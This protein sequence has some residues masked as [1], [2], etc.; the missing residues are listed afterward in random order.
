MI[1]QTPYV[2]GAPVGT[3]LTILFNVLMSEAKTGGFMGAND[4]A[5][6]AEV[7]ELVKGKIGIIIDMVTVP[8]VSEHREL[9]S[10]VCLF[11][12]E[13][14]GTQEHGATLKLSSQVNVTANITKGRLATIIVGEVEKAFV[15]L[16]APRII[17]WISM[18]ILV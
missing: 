16:L 8:T 3:P 10:S 14:D 1:E 12:R 11:I 5:F 17:E 15:S 13:P 6:P 9:A 18:Y 4:Y 2:R 7:G